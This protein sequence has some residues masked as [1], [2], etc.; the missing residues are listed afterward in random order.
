M[1]LIMHPERRSGTLARGAYAATPLYA[2]MT[3]ADIGDGLPHPL[4]VNLG[5]NEPVLAIRRVDAAADTLAP[6]I[7]QVAVDRAWWQGPS[8]GRRRRLLVRTTLSMVATRASTD[9]PMTPSRGP[10]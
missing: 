3:L 6:A 7:A 4:S 2:P 8:P 9:Q 10:A 1:R 5:A